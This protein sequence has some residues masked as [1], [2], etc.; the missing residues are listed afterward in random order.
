MRAGEARR[1]LFGDEGG[2]HL[3]PRKPRV[4]E[5]RV[6]KVEVVPQPIAPNL[7]T[8]ERVQHEA[9]RLVAARAVRDELG[10]HRVVVDGDLTALDDAIVHAD[11]AFASRRRHH[12]SLVRGHVP[13]KRAHRGQEPPQRVLGVHAALKAPAAR[14]DVGLR[15]RERLARRHLEH[16][17]D[18]IEARHHL[19]HRM[20]HLEPRVHLEK[21]VPLLRVD[22]ELDSTR[23]AVA[24]RLGE[25]DRLLAHRAHGRLGQVR[26]GRLLDHLLVAPLD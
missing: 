8:G 11:R 20:L 13:R 4:V 19:G 9:P 26:R 15:K 12:R 23:R 21:V 16:H 5:E 22:E 24:D 2:G 6:Q 3:A 10:N 7:V 25:C 18:E 14:E 17:L 1:E